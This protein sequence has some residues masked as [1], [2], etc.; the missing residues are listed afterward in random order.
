[1]TGR[2]SDIACARI[3]IIKMSAGERTTGI[4]VNRP[5]IALSVDKLDTVLSGKRQ[6]V[7]AVTGILVKPYCIL[8]IFSFATWS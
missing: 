6:V 4:K 1:L 7:L 3:R 2:A 8:H 5:M